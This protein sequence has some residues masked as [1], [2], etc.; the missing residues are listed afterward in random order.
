[1][2][3]NDNTNDTYILHSHILQHKDTH[4]LHSHILQHTPISMREAEDNAA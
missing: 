3:V 4:I 2:Y 1:M